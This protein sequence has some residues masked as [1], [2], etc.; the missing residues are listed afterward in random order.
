MG[1]VLED[2]RKRLLEKLGV[3]TQTHAE[4]VNATREVEGFIAT[5]SSNNITELVRDLNQEFK[6][7]REAQNELEK[8]N[9]GLRK[10]IMAIQVHCPHP[11][12]EVDSEGSME[13]RTC[14][15]CGR[16]RTLN[17]SISH[18]YNR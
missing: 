9:Y 5:L 18:L 7:N 16:G 14:K 3:D 1:I 4:A 2:V 15:L 10:L 6:Q 17:Y 12:E 13:L 11:N 8:K